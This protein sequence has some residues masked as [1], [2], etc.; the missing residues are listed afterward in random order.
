MNEYVKNIIHLG[1]HARMDHAEKARLVTINIFLLISL[2]LTVLFVLGF[3][4]AGSLS[5]VKALVYVPLILLIFFLHAKGHLVTARFFVSYG[6][7]LIVLA[8]ALMERRAGTEYLLMGLGCCSAVVFN[9]LSSVVV[10]FLFATTCYIGYQWYDS[11]TPFIPNPTVPYDIARNAI[12]ILS[13]FIVLAQSLVFRQ[14]INDYA[15]QLSQ[16]N[17]DTLAMNEELQ[18]AN[19]EL[20]AFSENLDL[21]V[22]QKSAQ[23]QA[24]VDAINVS[25]YSTVSDLE[26]K[27]ISINEKV[28]SLSGYS[29]EELIGQHYSILASGNHPDEFFTA[30]REKLMTGKTWRG[31]VEHKTKQGTLVWF[32]CILIPIRDSDG[33][34]RSFLTLGL[35]ITERKLHDQLQE[36]TLTLLESIA[37]RASHG[38]RGPLARINGLSNLVRQRIVEQ[39]EFELIAEKMIIC[40]QELNAAT[41]ELVAYVSN[42]QE[43]MM[44]HRQQI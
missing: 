9:R 21:L 42:H 28:V 27:F 13:A 10:A 32:D 35:P 15:D 14:L 33:V 3:L 1:Q 12:M 4:L 18:A 44:D 25:I 26:G 17:H 40:S 22:R 41:S 24:Y 6:F 19:E 39:H 7:M 23:L 20:T 8:V 37:F 31:D 30:R 16:A 2:V 34:I 43:L 5:V 29:S 11:H 38:I 36:E